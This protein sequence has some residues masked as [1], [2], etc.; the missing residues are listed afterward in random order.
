MWVYYTIAV[1]LFSLLNV[2]STDYIGAVVE[3]QPLEGPTV[4][5]TL[6]E[7]L[8]NYIY[9]IEQAKALGAQIIVFPEYGLTTL[10]DDPE[11]YS[12]PVPNVG[13]TN[14]TNEAYVLLKLS[15]AAF[16]HNIY[17][18]ANLLER[19]N[20]S[21][22][23]TTYYYN[24]NV[25][26]SSNGTLVARYRKMNLYNEPKLTPGTENAIFNTDFGTFAVFTCMDIM[27]YNSSQAVLENTGVTDVV[28]P[29]AWF[30]HFPF[31]MALSVQQGYALANKV[32]LLAANVN[33][34]SRALGGS[35]IISSDG[36]ILR[37][38]L[39]DVSSNNIAYATLKPPS[40]SSRNFALM[41]FDIFR[42]ETRQPL[43]NF[44]NL[45]Y[46]EYDKFNYKPVNLSSENVT[47]E[48]CHGDF[49]CNFNL[50]IARNG[51]SNTSEVYKLAAFKGQMTYLNKTELPIRICTL[52]GCVNDE[53]SSCGVWP[54]TAYTTLFRQMTVW[55][56]WES[57]QPDQFIRP[58]GIRGDWEPL[59]NATYLENKTNET[60]GASFNVTRPTNNVVSFGLYITGSASVAQVSWF[61][62]VFMIFVFGGF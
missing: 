31:Y 16:E 46:F 35:S 37:R 53:I 20:A 21:D 15:N 49:C 48:I 62:V 8:K 26:F 55:G 12:I 23:N 51:T 57:A 7:N 54:R 28:F 17:I 60:V 47:E 29:T 30:S 3:Y 10:V 50:V 45:T 52:L 4:N 43:S 33:L 18:V 25:V 39:T 34:P 5:T 1:V 24:T 38:I 2:G 22:S 59:Y 13:T 44:A 11:E 6:E 58:T 36:T 61:V 41:G 27:Y 14:F 40:S 19:A 56:N 42:N 32:N 9:H